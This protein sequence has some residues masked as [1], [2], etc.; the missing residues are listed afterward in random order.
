MITLRWILNK[1]WGYGLDFL[2]SGW[3]IMEG[4][5]GHGNEPSGTKE[6]RIF[7]D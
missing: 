7:F 6:G 2:G 3:G 4:S 1:V 5:C